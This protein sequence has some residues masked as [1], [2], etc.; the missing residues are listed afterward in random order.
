MGRC[1][2]LICTAHLNSSTSFTHDTNDSFN[3]RD[4]QPS[5]CSGAESNKGANGRVGDGTHLRGLAK[6]P[7]HARKSCE[8][9]KTNFQI[10][11]CRSHGRAARQEMNQLINE[12]TNHLQ[13]C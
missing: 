13:F 6:D 1:I 9:Q 7:M 5:P 4:G 8:Q 2:V 12:S 11:C 3:E 10:H